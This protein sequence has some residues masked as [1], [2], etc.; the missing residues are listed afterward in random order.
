MSDNLKLCPFCGAPGTNP[1]LHSKK[2]Y[3]TTI[4]IS[5]QDGIGRAIEPPSDVLAES[6]NS[7]Y[8]SPELEKLK[9]EHA[10]L[11]KAL[12]ALIVA[13]NEY[14][15]YQHDGDPDTEDARAMGEMM[16][17]DLKQDGTLDKITKMVDLDC[18]GK[19]E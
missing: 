4:Y 6:W 8:E 13:A 11:F 2:C 18:N 1:L 10:E 12:S 5:L 3:I 19:E 14:A 15:D 16:L 9:K 17:D 7:R